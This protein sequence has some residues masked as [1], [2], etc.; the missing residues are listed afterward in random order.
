MMELARTHHQYSDLEARPLNTAYFWK[1]LLKAPIKLMPYHGAHN[2]GSP[3][4]STLP[5]CGGVSYWGNGMVGVGMPPFIIGA[6]GCTGMN[7]L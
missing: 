7:R 5:V 6:P 4:G 3:L 1:N 2:G